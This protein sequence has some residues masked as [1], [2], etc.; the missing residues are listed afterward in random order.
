MSLNINGKKIKE[1]EKDKCHNIICNIFK[2]K[3]IQLMLFFI[4]MV[5]SINI[6]SHISNKETYKP[7]NMT[8]VKVE[9]EK[10]MDDMDILM[11]KL[12]K[13][14]ELKNSKQS[15][16]NKENKD[17]KDIR[18]FK[19]T[20]EIREVQKVEPKS[21]STLF[22]KIPNDINNS[23]PVKKEQKMT[24]YEDWVDEPNDN[25]IKQD[26]IIKTNELMNINSE[27]DTEVER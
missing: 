2:N 7:D 9:H 23:K 11:E 6:I 15:K 13:E 18:E 5:F 17:N 8:K 4:L 12:K 10:Q 27:K 16:E 22:E 21:V 26:E 3:L 25:N 24:R 1:K 19:A 14:K 20:P